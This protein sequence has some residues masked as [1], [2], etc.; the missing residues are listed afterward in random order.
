MLRPPIYSCHKQRGGGGRRAC[1][2]VASDCIKDILLLLAE[3][4]AAAA[5]G[6][7]A[8]YR[9][10]SCMPA[11]LHRYLPAHIL[12]YRAKRCESESESDRERMVK[13][14]DKRP[15]KGRV[16]NLYI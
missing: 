9:R 1:A 15:G 7:S 12:G 6:R 10:R 13:R 2:R 4:T 16:P 11:V 14:A 8:H 3:F 5:A